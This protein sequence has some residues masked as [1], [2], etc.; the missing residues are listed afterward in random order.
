MVGEPGAAY[1]FEDHRPGYGPTNMVG[2]D[3]LWLNQDGSGPAVTRGGMNARKKRSVLG[4]LVVVFSIVLLSIAAT[5]WPAARPAVAATA[6]WPTYLN[7]QPRTGF[8]AG[9]T[10]ITP[11]TAPNLSVLWSYHAAGSVSAEP[12]EANGNVYWGSWNGYEHDTTTSGT[13]RWLTYLGQTT[14]S[15]CNPQVAGV[16]STATIATVTINGAATTVDFVGGGNGYFYALNAAT[17][18]VIW[19]TLLGAPPAHFLWSSA[20]LYKGSIYEGVSSFGDCPLVRGKLVKLSAATGAV[21]STFYTAP[22][23]CVGAGVW[24]SAALDPASGNIFFGTGNAGS[25]GTAEPLAVALVELSP[26]LSLVSHWQIP[27]A[28]HGPDS[29]FGSTPTMF[30]GTLNGTS[31]PLVGLQN[32][33][34]VYYAFRRAA[35]SAG[36]VWRARIAAAGQCPECGKGDIPPSAWDGQRLYIAGGNTTITGV[37]CPGSLQAINPGSGKLIWQKCMPDGPVL[38][39]VTAVRGVAIVGE[40]PKIMAVSTS[41]GGTL[42]SYND[43]S[44]G[45]RFWGPASV[46]AGVA[47]I[48]NQDGI[49]YA[50]H[51]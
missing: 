22:S 36:P 19:K 18:A 34:G 39:A 3:S 12:V 33:N 27:A 9:E 14:D 1:L 37:F 28:Q 2:P 38:G 35:V 23:G 6:G 46:S 49:I 8:D 40:G 25:C 10:S 15:N 4:F 20:L 51:A 7:V 41:T 43:T 26:S 11:S 30:S 21:Q 45:S 13:R 24:G 32:K 47:F 42:F 31:T 44:A 17:G 50:F 5:W 29:D 16:A 48:G